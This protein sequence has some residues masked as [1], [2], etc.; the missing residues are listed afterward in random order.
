MNRRFDSE[1]I[2]L[3]K[4]MQGLLPDSDNFLKIELLVPFL[5]HY[6][7]DCHEVAAEISTATKYL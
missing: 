4:A 3:L 2:S 5:K 1:N 6:E 7:I